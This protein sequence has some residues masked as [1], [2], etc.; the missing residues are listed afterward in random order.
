MYVAKALYIY[1][2]IYFTR[3][4]GT[5]D[6]RGGGVGGILYLVLRENKNE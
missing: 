3:R 1:M 4:K 6:S 5:R 2:Y